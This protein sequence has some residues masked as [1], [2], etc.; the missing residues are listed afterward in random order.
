MALTRTLD[1]TEGQEEVEEAIIVMITTQLNWV[2]SICKCFNYSLFINCIACF[3]S[4][5]NERDLNDD[6]LQNSGQRSN[7]DRKGYGNSTGGEGKPSRI[8]AYRKSNYPGKVD[9]RSPSGLDG[10]NNSDDD[11]SAGA[12][13]QRI[14]GDFNTAVNNQKEVGQITEVVNQFER[15]YFAAKKKMNTFDYQTLDADSVA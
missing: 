5:N 15:N 13:Q 10:A 7:R 4:E 3:I 14:E 11:E 9:A 2:I 1:E 6:Q 8:S 12:R